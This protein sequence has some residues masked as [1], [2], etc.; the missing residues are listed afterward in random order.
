MAVLESHHVKPSLLKSFLGPRLVLKGKPIKGQYNSVL[1]DTR[2]DE[3]KEENTQE[4]KFLSHGHLICIWL[5]WR[6]LSWQ[7]FPQAG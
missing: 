7:E 5:L 1:D 3:M 6:L 4:M 2:S